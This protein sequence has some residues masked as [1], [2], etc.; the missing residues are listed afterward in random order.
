MSSPMQMEPPPD[1]DATHGPTLLAISWAM[2]GVDVVIVA[3]RLF[4]RFTKRSVGLDDYF[5]LIALVSEIPHISYLWLL[6]DFV[7]QLLFIATEAAVTEIVYYGLGRHM[8]YVPPENASPFLKWI[9]ILQ[10][11]ALFTLTFAKASIALLLMRLMGADALWRKRFLW[12]NMIIFFIVTILSTIFDLVSCKPISA[13]W[14]P[15]SDASCW[16]LSINQDWATFLSGMPLI[17]TEVQ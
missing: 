12:L 3:L 9:F 7:L 15:E 13:N 6:T 1:G 14:Q 4:V 5:M 11:F 16:P 8:Y 2:V 17:C 10:S